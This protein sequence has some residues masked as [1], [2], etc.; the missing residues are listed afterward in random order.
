MHI[1][2]AYITMLS[3]MWRHK[4]SLPA[5]L[6]HYPFIVPLFGVLCHLTSV[7]SFFG[8]VATKNKNLAIEGPNGK[9]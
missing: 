5:T 9:L 1:Y 2:E 6:Y 3:C 7:G 4:D 8:C